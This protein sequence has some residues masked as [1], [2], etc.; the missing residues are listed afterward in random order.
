MVGTRQFDET[1]VMQR[2]LNVFRQKGLAAT[3]MI[4]LAQAT[5]VHRGSLY[6]AYGGKEAIFLSAFETYADDYMRGIRTAL[7]QTD[8][9]A[10]LAAFVETV[11]TSMTAGSPARGCLSTRTATEVDETPPA[12]QDRIRRWLDELQET[13][14]IGLRRR[15]LA[16]QLTLP[17]EEAARLLVTFTRGLAVME[18]VY[19]DEAQLRDISASLIRVLVRQAGK[20]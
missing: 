18:R 2:A 17:P 12:V 20:D 10:A 7:D 3:S 15:C 19:H 1:A 4:D 6:N 5:G 11:L 8:A 13:I 14:E 9:R 16:D